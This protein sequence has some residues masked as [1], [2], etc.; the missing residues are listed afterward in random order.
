[1][2][3]RNC[4]EKDAVKY[5]QYSNGEF[6]SKECARGFSTKAKRKEINEKVSK[7][8]TKP[9]SETECPVCK[10][11]FEHLR[12]RK[13]VCCSGKCSSINSGS[14]ED[15]KQKLR[16]A[17]I[18]LVEQGKHKGWASRNI[19]SYPEKFFRKVLSNNDLLDKCKI[20]FSVNKRLLG[21]E[22][23]GNYFL[24]FY[25]PEKGI[26]LEIDGSQHEMIEERKI[27][28]KKRDKFLR[29]NDYIVYRI[30]WNEINSDKGKK[31]MEGKIDKFLEFY[32]WV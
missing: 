30:K 26:D 8:L 23:N 7:T 4:N 21:I 20:N 22:E 5:S 1:M 16:D 32:I 2:K 9:L 29:K 15:V 11:K 17:Q 18:K 19:L 31:K 24:D 12:Y 28:D 10:K 13:R 25:F 14:R 3:C 6:C 27:S